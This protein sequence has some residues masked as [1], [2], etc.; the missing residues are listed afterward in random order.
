MKKVRKNSLALKM[1]ALGLLAHYA[2][3]ILL[4]QSSQLMEKMTLLGSI[5]YLSMAGTPI[6][7]LCVMA[8][9]KNRGGS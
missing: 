3:S 1:T 5:L 2:Y 7:I 9:I 6:I 4:F 8:V